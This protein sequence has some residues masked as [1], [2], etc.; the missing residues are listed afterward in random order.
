MLSKLRQFVPSSVF[1]NIYNALITPHLTSPMVLSLGETAVKR[2]GDK[3]LVIQKRALRLIYSANRQDNAIP[4]F[5]NAKVLPLNFLYYESG[6]KLNARHRR[7]KYTD[8]YF[9]LV[10][11]DI[12]FTSLFYTLINFTKF[13]HKKTRLGIQKNAFSHVGAE[14]WNE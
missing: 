1:V 5:V 3:I 11:K 8:K 14:I 6:L 7:K 13:L 2:I 4:S 9:E 10:F 12:K